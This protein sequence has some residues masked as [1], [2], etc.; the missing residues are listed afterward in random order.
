MEGNVGQT[1]RTDEHLLNSTNHT[2]AVLAVKILTVVEHCGPKPV[3]AG[4]IFH[5]KVSVGADDCKPLRLLLYSLLVSSL[6]VK[7]MRR[8]KMTACVLLY[9]EDEPVWPYCHSASSSTHARLHRCSN[10]RRSA[11]L[12]L[13]ARWRHDAPAAAAAAEWKQSHVDKMRGR[14]RAPPQYTVKQ[15]LGIKQTELWQ[16]VW[17]LTICYTWIK[18]TKQQQKNTNKKVIKKQNCNYLN[19]HQL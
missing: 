6:N 2:D 18:V 17:M 5:L 12:R 1:V 15:N 8:Q 3:V 14:S 11:F 19:Q 16:E 10:R 7:K 9:G 4:W 13:A